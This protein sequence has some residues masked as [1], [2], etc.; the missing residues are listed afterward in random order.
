V[1]SG[2]RFGPFAIAG[3]IV[4][5]LGLGGD[6]TVSNS[7]AADN[8][9][10]G[11]LFDV[12]SIDLTNGPA[13]TTF[14]AREMVPGDAAM[15]A[16]TL[17]NPGRDPMSYTMSHGPIS[18]DGT[19][20]AAALV[21]T[22]KTVGSSCIDYDGITLYDGPLDQAAFGSE[23]IGRLL[24]AATAEILCFRAVLPSDAGNVLQGLGTSVELT[25]G[26]SWQAAKR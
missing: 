13:V 1:T 20:L 16:I 19:A 2:R 23:G 21:L 5:S 22:V 8:A 4:V 25:F 26:A 3:L 17:A 9:I 11:H 12:S 6:G 15:T 18:A 7:R 14:S 10:D 24:P